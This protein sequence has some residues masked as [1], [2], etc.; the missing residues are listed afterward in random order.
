MFFLNA[1]SFLIDLIFPKACVSCGANGSYLCKNCSKKI[2]WKDQQTCPRCERPRMNGKFC[3]GCSHG[4]NF[5]S[6][7]VCAKYEGILS[8]LIK[9]YKYSFVKEVARELTDILESGLKFLPKENVVLIPAPLSRKRKMFRG[10]NQNLFLAEYLS[11]QLSALVLD[12]LDKEKETL[13]QAKLSKEKRLLNVNNSMAFKK[14][15]KTPEVL[16]RLK[17]SNIVLLDDVAGTLATL[18]ECAR[19]LREVGV[20]KISC[21]V[22]CRN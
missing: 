8:R 9:L 1:F 10:Y 6:L 3:V 21:L 7:V 12:C 17:N 13:C 2:R 19:A 20:L 5:E 18:N 22:I 4:F 15:C 14:K 16:E 11:R